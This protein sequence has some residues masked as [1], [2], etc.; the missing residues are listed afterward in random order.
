MSQPAIAKLL[1]EVHMATNYIKYKI[2]YWEYVLF[3]ASCLIS[4]KPKEIEYFDLTMYFTQPIEK[5]GENE[6]LPEKFGELMNYYDDTLT[7]KRIFVPKVKFERVDFDS[8]KRLDYEYVFSGLNKFRKSL[9]LLSANNLMRDYNK[10]I[11]RLKTPKI[12]I[13]KSD[14]SE[15]QSIKKEISDAI[16][17]NLKSYGKTSC[18]VIRNEINGLLNSGKVA[19]KIDLF[20]YCTPDSTLPSTNRIV[21]PGGDIYEG[22]IFNGKANG[23]GTFWFH[24]GDSYTGQ[25]INDKPEGSG[26]FKYKNGD[27]YTGRVFRG[28]PEGNG[29]FQFKNGD[30]YQGLS[31]NGKP[32]GSGT[33]TFRNGNHYEGEFKNGL[34][35]GNG[36]KTFVHGGIISLLDIRKRIVKDGDYL[37]GVWRNGEPQICKWYNSDGNYKETLVLGN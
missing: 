28:K 16:R 18:K 29:S 33:F 15:S 12:L 19:G 32:D 30:K 34:F 20:F 22:D 37:I 24:N 13:E 2:L 8:P 26:T 4:C 1:I 14:T 21:Y 17:I 35:D 3:I 27:M 5:V 31:L 25:V 9:G 36:R 23:K 11:K 7:N 10:N 6:P